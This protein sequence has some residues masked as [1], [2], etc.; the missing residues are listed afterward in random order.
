[1]C[2]IGSAITILFPDPDISPFVT[3]RVRNR[4]SLPR[5]TSTLKGS[6]IF[7]S[8]KNIKILFVFS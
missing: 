6:E 8:P 2:K 4:S 5:G 1:M 7:L 3:T